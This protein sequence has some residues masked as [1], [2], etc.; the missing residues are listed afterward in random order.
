MHRKV[1]APKCSIHRNCRGIE[2]DA[3]NL[4]VRNDQLNISPPE[5]KITWSS[6]GV[7][8]ISFNSASVASPTPIAKILTPLSRS[9][10]AAAGTWPRSCGRPSVIKIRIF[11]TSSRH[12]ALVSINLNNYLVP[13][14]GWGCLPECGTSMCV[15]MFIW[16]CID[17]CIEII[18]TID[19]ISK[20]NVLV[21]MNCWG[22]SED[23][24]TNIT[25][26]KVK[27]IW[28]IFGEILRMNKV[29]CFDW[30]GSINDKL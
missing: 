8:A 2:V 30:W 4:R 26:S 12:L 19:W 24:D 14:E 28:N 3:P 25:M 1:D 17:S 20:F 5:M 29:L 16:H 9:D 15:A 6:Y 22:I 10:W 27:C 13:D 21:V 11:G 7:D 18:C 23:T